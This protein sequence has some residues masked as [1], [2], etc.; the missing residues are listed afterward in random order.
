[1][2][3]AIAVAPNNHNHSCPR[4]FLRSVDRKPSYN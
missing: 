2:I 4:Q 1:V 3:T